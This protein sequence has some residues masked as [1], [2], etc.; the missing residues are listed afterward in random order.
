MIGPD[1][2]ECNKI[3]VSITLYA[4]LNIPELN[5][6]LPQ[7]VNFMKTTVHLVTT[8]FWKYVTGVSNN[9]DTVCIMYKNGENVGYKK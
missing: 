7:M 9:T 2:K 5:E 4:T 1:L 3:E 6:I 8:T